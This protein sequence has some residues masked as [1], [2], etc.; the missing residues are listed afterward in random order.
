[1]HVLTKDEFKSLEDAARPL[2]EWLSANYH[3]HATVIVSKD[4]AELLVGQARVR[5]DPEPPRD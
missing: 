2:M 1:M 5:R 4:D 3:P